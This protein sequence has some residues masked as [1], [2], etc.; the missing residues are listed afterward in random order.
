MV[1]QASNC[2]IGSLAIEDVIPPIFASHLQ[3]LNLHVCSLLHS[4]VH[5]TALSRMA[6]CK[7]MNTT[8]KASA[9][10]TTNFTPAVGCCSLQAPPETCC[11]ACPDASPCSP[12]TSASLDEACNGHWN[13]MALRGATCFAKPPALK[14]LLVNLRFRSPLSFALRSRNF[15]PAV[16]EVH[17]E[18]QL[19]WV[20]S[21]S[22]VN[23]SSESK[24]LVVESK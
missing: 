14:S 17:L 21:R 8:L 12:Q 24:R 20:L 7:D 4:Q 13:T 23:P 10:H 3:L 2:N 11:H 18:M 1:C 16:G 9:S 6:T 5:L 22:E 19:G 15:N